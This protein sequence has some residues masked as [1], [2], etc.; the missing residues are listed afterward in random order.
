MTVRDYE[1][2]TGIKIGLQFGTE[3]ADNIDRCVGVR[4]KS[5]MHPLS[6]DCM[7]SL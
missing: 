2:L 5:S 4:L 3:R 6:P 7:E 1:D